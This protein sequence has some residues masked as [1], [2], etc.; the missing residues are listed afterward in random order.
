MY[1]TSSKCSL[2]NLQ[3]NGTHNK[4]GTTCLIYNSI[5]CKVHRITKICKVQVK[6]IIV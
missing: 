1:S 2:Y 6:G 5:S 3:T 4:K